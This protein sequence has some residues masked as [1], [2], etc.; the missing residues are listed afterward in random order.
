MQF[1]IRLNSIRLHSCNFE[2]FN[3]I[4]ITLIDKDELEVERTEILINIY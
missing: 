3:G 4:I 2:I 1:F